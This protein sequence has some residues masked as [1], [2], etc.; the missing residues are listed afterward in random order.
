M[1]KIY[2][3]CEFSNYLIVIVMGFLE[4]KLLILGVCCSIIME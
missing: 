1:F 2:V 3:V 4:G